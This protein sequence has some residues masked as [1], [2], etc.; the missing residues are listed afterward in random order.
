MSNH[1]QRSK[2]LAEKD[3]SPEQFAQ[4]QELQRIKTKDEEGRMVEERGERGVTGGGGG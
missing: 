3:M 1:E 4:L 2:A